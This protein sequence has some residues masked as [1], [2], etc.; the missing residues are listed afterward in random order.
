M[1]E[2]GLSDSGNLMSFGFSTAGWCGTEMDMFSQLSDKGFRELYYSAPYHWGMANPVTLEVFTYTEGD[3][4]FISCK[5]MEK[6]LLELNSYL[7]WLRDNYGESWIYGDGELL[8]E[9]LC[10]SFWREN[11]V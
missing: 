8:F 5:S 10:T 6:F 9:R 4:T 2:L 1:D 3:L 11:N 7:G